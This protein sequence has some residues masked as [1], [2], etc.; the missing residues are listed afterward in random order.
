MSQVTERVNQEHPKTRTRPPLSALNIIT[1]VALLGQALV[2]TADLL[3]AWLLQGAFVPPFFIGIIPALIA[4]GLI[5]RRLRWAPALGAGVALLTM[6]LYLTDPGELYTLAHPGNGFINFMLELLVLAFA[7]VVIVAGIGATIRN[8]QG[9]M[10][11]PQRWLQPILTGF[12]GIVVGMLILAALAA[13]NPTASSASSITSGEPSVHME[14]A[15]FSPN[16]VLVSKG[17]RLLIV[18]D[19]P[20]EHILQNG[21]WT[22]NGTARSLAEPGAPVVHNVDIPG[23]SV[24]IGPFNT[25]GTFHVYCTVHPG[26]NLTITVQ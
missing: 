3:D 10:P 15:S 21:M 8:Y 19:A 4:A 9:S 26:M 11:R 23:G 22:A 17:D 20:V 16:V 2:V 18:N 24:Q 25:A 7:L 14:W 1:L 5:T 13:A 6:A 12:T